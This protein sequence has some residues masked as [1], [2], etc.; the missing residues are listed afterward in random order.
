LGF[1][2]SALCPGDGP[3]ASKGTSA[4]SL[5]GGGAASSLSET[6][7]CSLARAFPVQCCA[8]PGN[9]DG[10]AEMVE[11]ISPRCVL[12]DL[13]SPLRISRTGSLA[14]IEG[15]EE[16][17]EP[18]EGC[19]P[20]ELAPWL[21][22]ARA[23]EMNT[24]FDVSD[25]LPDLEGGDA[26]LELNELMAVMKAES[27]GKQTIQALGDKILLGKL[28]SNL[29]IPQMP[30]LFETYTEVDRTEVQDL[31]DGLLSSDRA[32]ALDI[33]VK[34]THLSNGSGALV[35]SPEVWHAQGFGVDKLVTHMET[36]L[37]ETAAESESEALRSL[38]PGFIVQPR[39]RSCVDFGHPLEVRVVTLWGK[40]RL[41]VWWWGRANDPGKPQRTTWIVRR[42][43]VPG[44]L[45]QKDTWEAI[46]EHR[47]ANQG[48]DVALEIFRRAMPGL[49]VAAEAIATA[50]GAPFL[51]SDFFVGSREW[52]VRLNEVA[53]GSGV[54]YRRLSTT[55]NSQLV[56][57]GPAIARI[58]QEGMEVCSRR[59]RP[60]HFLTRLGASGGA[61]VVEPPEWW[62]W[63]RSEEE[64]QPAEPAMAVSDV[65]QSQRPRLPK[66]VLS[67]FSKAALTGVKSL[68]APACQTPRGQGP[69]CVTVA[70]LSA[71]MPVLPVASAGPVLAVKLGTPRSWTVASTVALASRA[72]L[73]V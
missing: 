56:D 44:K 19:L 39:Y 51:R 15:E 16:E 61:Y 11:L 57:D 2:L 6:V 27:A 59:H 50:V 47:G 21:E 25:A 31:V 42:P 7:F 8:E 23:F 43:A 14:S 40:A 35:L 37:E 36:Y 41:G 4:M 28:L 67:D 38:V 68:A 54:D 10:S 34:P 5:G 30:V 65:P 45:T 9:S 3:L 72:R 49:A 71:A 53:Y 58:L 1:P 52:G 63:W 32:N 33:V 13:G 12:K 17:E 60:T 64:E 46:H 29:G 55:G 20:A 69:G 18:P 26:F 62:Q 73:P 24:D 70:P 22:A 48:F 66:W